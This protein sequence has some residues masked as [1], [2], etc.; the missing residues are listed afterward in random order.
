MSNELIEVGGGEGGELMDAA[1]AGRLL[2]M[3]ERYGDLRDLANEA[4]GRAEMARAA[5]QFLLTVSTSEL[6]RIKENKLF[7]ALKG[8]KTADGQRLDGTW[9]D[10]CEI[11]LGRSRQQVDE[12]IA[13]WRAFGE[14]ALEA[15]Q[16]AGIGYREL[17]ELRRVPED[18]RAEL[19]RVA[20]QE[21][22]DA[23]LD[24]AEELIARAH[25]KTEA[26]EA[27]TA[28]TQELALSLEERIQDLREDNK[29]KDR[30][31]G[32]LKTE[33]R[34]LKEG[35]APD[36]TIQHDLM[37]HANA[38]RLVLAQALAR[39]DQLQELMRLVELMEP[40][41][42][43]TPE[44]DA[45]RLG[46][47]QVYEGL[48][49]PLLARVHLIGDLYDRLHNELHWRTLPPDEL[50]A[51]RQQNEAAAAEFIAKNKPL[52]VVK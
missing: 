10:F 46:M 29:T 23:L 37:A 25:K 31:I 20:A 12:D 18:D 35:Q 7:R 32:E 8:K 34:R 38:M 49:E 16:R 43:G 24:T 13:N 41:P 19:G 4:L 27:K 39:F 3:E 51:L 11:G 2:A 30:L 28:A 26:A 52:S 44:A 45:Y 40:P 47:G 48:R 1:E 42:E 6:A 9:E 15:M 36:V 33:A 14:E 22:K 5:S 21:S 17:R 50:E